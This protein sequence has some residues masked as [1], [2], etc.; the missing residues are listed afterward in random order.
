MKSNF[1]NSSN[2]SNENPINISL[3]KDQKLIETIL[4]KA[5]SE[6]MSILMKSEIILISN[7]SMLLFH[8]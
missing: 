3:Y 1:I 4:Y 8:L 7:H 6:K 5:N 2:L